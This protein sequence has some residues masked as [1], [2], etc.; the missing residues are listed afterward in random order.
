MKVNQREAFD[1]RLRYYQTRDEEKFEAYLSKLR[2][3]YE[4]L[5]I[6][7]DARKFID[8][9]LI[10]DGYI[11]NGK[12]TAEGY[13]FI[14]DGGYVRQLELEE[15]KREYEEEL[16]NSTLKTNKTSRYS[17]YFSGIISFVTICVLLSTCEKETTIRTDSSLQ[18]TT[19]LDKHI[20]PLVTFLESQKAARSS[21]DS[22]RK[23]VQRLSMK[24]DS[25]YLVINKLNNEKIQKRKSQ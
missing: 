8:D 20:E 15:I 4:K 2:N 12:I 7:I 3:E 11:E 25:T 21:S 16:R 10:A 24:L 19:P 17:M 9:K 22:L 14:E 13:F 5:G 23:E 6:K 1:A 18:V